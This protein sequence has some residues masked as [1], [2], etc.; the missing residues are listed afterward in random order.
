ME[1]YYVTEDTE[2]E[3][4]RGELRACGRVRSRGGKGYT[5]GCRIAYDQG[6]WDFLR[7]NDNGSLT[8]VQWTSY[9][10]TGTPGFRVQDDATESECWK[11]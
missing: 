7:A 1:R 2:V 8:L 3:A 11:K 9:T 6:M 5:V 10:D 4:L